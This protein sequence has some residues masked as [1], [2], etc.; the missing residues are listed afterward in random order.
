MHAQLNDLPT[1]HLS[2]DFAYLQSLVHHEIHRLTGLT[3]AM[4]RALRFI[5][6]FVLC[7]AI[8]SACSLPSHSWPGHV[9]AGG[10]WA[11]P[12]ITIDVFGDYQCPYTAK[13][14]PTLRSLALLGE[15]K[16]R[17]R[18]HLFEGGVGNGVAIDV[19]GTSR[20]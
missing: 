1:F 16:V 13:A 3:V 14:W 20:L 2:P 6:A 15:Q 18:Y 7:F 17:V 8:H 4:A 12:Q 11:D 5:V 19:R 10:H 9:L